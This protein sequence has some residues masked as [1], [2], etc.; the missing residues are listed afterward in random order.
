MEK[1]YIC[2][3]CGFT[4]ILQNEK[5]DCPICKGKLI[6]EEELKEREELQK[7]IE[8]EKSEH[9]DFTPQEDAREEKDYMNELIAEN[10]VK[11]FKYAIKTIG[12]ERTWLTIECLY[13]L[14]TRLAYRKYFFK[15]GG[16]VPEGE[17]I[18]IEEI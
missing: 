13:P 11:D 15:A 17:P 3:N 2:D 9:E 7:L 5:C 14:S 18:N 16:L 10:I 8:E 1:K 12:N 6:S 4:L